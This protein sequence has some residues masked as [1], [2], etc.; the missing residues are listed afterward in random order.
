MMN[1]TPNAEETLQGVKALGKVLE[2]RPDLPDTERNGL[3]KA[4]SNTLTGTPIPPADAQPTK[5]QT[6][7]KGQEAPSATNGRT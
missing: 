6:Q 3:I 4:V 5:D 2:D 1:R 7:R